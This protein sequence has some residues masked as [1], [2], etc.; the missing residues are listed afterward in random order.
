MIKFLKIVFYNFLILITF[1]L[2][3]EIFFGYW[4][5]KDNFGPYMREHRMKNQRIEWSNGNEKITYFYRRNYH[6]F[7]GADINPSD[8]DAIIMGGSV[9][10]ER[11]KPDKY[12]ITGHLS[13]N[14][15]EDFNIKLTNAGVEAQ[16]TRGMVM[17]F[18][19]WL[20]KLN[21]FSPK[22]I[23]F[24][25]GINDMKWSENEKLNDFKSDGHLLNPNT[26]EVIKD[27]VKSRSILYD[28]AR[29][30][31]F[32]YLPREAFE[33]YDGKIDENYKKNYNFTSY[34]FAKNNYNITELQ[35]KY[36]KKIKHYV[37]RID[38]LSRLSKILGSTPI[39]ITNLAS[40]GHVEE[41][42]ILNHELLNHCE[43]KKYN[44]I[45]LA[46]QINGKPEYWKDGTHTSKIGS[47]IFA[48]LIYKD[49]KKIIEINN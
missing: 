27:N 36:N 44:C 3:T 23:L 15:E 20:F 46:K 43:L 38:E 24:Y 42:F 37:Y 29:I 39:F 19:N 26:H 9:I 4:F 12:T 32:K 45:D 49:L 13:K 30:F 48:K 31:K 2:L 1:I 14:L 35:K 40:P 7:R 6:G 8:I 21:E 11:Y 16:S 18:K 25:V 28:S 22:F 47:E 17:S 5:D 34:T 41:I 33:K 10:D